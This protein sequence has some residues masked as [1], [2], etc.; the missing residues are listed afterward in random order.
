MK[1]RTHTNNGSLI[2]IVHVSLSLEMGGMEKLL[3]EFAS[4]A[5]QQ[6]FQLHFA[7]MENRGVLADEVE[8][9]GWPV[10][11]LGKR[12][13][14]R[15]GLVLRLARIFRR[16]KPD[17][18][19]AHNT[20]ACIYAAPAARLARVPVVLATRHG[21]G[22][23]PGSRQAWLFALSTRFVDH[24]VCV[25]KDSGDIAVQLGIPPHRVTTIW[26]GIDTRKFAVSRPNPDGPALVVARLAPE[27]DLATLLRAVPLIVQRAPHWRLQIIGNGPCRVGL[28]A[29]TDELGLNQ[30][31]QFFGQQSDVPERLRKASM[32]LLPSLSE[33]VSLA[34]LE[35]MAS[36][37]PAVATRVS[38][39]VEVVRHEETGLLVAP[40][41]PAAIADAIVRL[42]SDPAIAARM[43]AAA[44]RRVED[45]FDIREMVHEYE[46]TYLNLLAI[47]GTRHKPEELMPLGLAQDKDKP[48]SNGLPH[49]PRTPH[50]SPRVSTLLQASV[51]QGYETVVKRRK[52]FSYYRELEKTQWHSLDEINAM[53]L[54]ALHNILLHAQQHS[55]YYRDL[56]QRLG[57]DAGQVHS[58]ADLRRWPLITRETIRTHRD[59]MRSTVAGLR[60][61]SKTTGGSSGAP[62]TLDV[63]YESNDRRNAARLRGYGWAG[64]TP[65]TRQFHLWGVPLGTRPL[66][67][68]L[69]DHLYHR[70]LNRHLVVNTFSLSDARVPEIF[71][72]YNNFCPDI[73]VAYTNPL[74]E[75]ARSLRSRGLRPRQPRSIVVGAEKL[76][77]FQ[78][79]LIEEVFQAPVFETYGS[80]EFMLIGAE[81]DRHNGLHL[82]SEHLL[83]EVLDEQGNPAAEGQEGNVAI[84][85][86]FNQAM[87]F[88]RYLNG[89]RALAGF[90]RCDCGRGLPLLR[91]VVGR[92]LD[93]LTTPEGHRIPGEFFIYLLKDFAAIDR[94]Q[95]IQQQTDEI[96]LKIVASLGWTPSDE[97]TIRRE[98]IAIVGDSVR[99]V[100]ERV[101]EITLTRAGKLQVVVNQCSAR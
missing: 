40:R 30:Y 10:T 94:F 80:R 44:R 1:M 25:S 41:D 60:S 12:P 4:H 11:T 32:F 70:W 83:V 85:D 75:F 54:C 69:K 48:L 13:G 3:V 39:N 68:R 28:E 56:W 26:N 62:L 77:L 53:Q 23:A 16:L 22:P 67:S 98:I 7:C 61:I 14:L 71:A 88:I 6:R 79:E 72:H 66:L 57:L 43:G 9:L 37:L 2:R 95:V 63:S 59:A 35:A 74:Y 21:Q 65:G 86:M 99:I 15:P 52:T 97:K 84:T 93:I 78:R 17:V 29:L 96:R 31:V 82:T 87:P 73:V 91:K 46:Q 76:H 33:G 51:I 90:E 81:C 64:A 19:H 38:G 50:R 100:I 47:K 27:K 34:L 8:A 5:D 89:D 36:G 49:M 24:V 101:D 20:V 18:V 45:S 42:A 92:Q 58:V 55:P